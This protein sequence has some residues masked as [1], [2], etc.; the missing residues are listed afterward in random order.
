MNP[1]QIKNRSDL[2]PR[3]DTALRARACGYAQGSVHSG[4]VLPATIPAPITRLGVLATS[5]AFV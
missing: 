5:S 4:A 1:T 3:I 2:H